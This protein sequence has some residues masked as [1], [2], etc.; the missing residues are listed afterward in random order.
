MDGRTARGGEYTATRYFGR[1]NTLGRR[2]CRR[3]RI[4]KGGRALELVGCLRATAS[5]AVVGV[6][7]CV[8]SL[9]LASPVHTER[10]R[11]PTITGTTEEKRN[12]CV[13]VC[14]DITAHSRPLLPR[15]TKPVR[16]RTTLRGH[17]AVLTVHRTRPC[18]VFVRA[19]VCV[20]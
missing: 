11:P 4:D 3:A 2:L 15:N 6:L 17:F 14:A 5:Q 20:D 10:E 12:A 18:R 7:I 9:A 8:F 13:C 16:T 19:C 1:G